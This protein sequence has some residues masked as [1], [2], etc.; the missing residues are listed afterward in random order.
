MGTGGK[1]FL[2]PWSSVKSVVNGFLCD[3]WVMGR[4][5]IRVPREPIRLRSWRASSLGFGGG[6]FREISFLVIF[7]P[8]RFINS[9]IA[10]TEDRINRKG[11]K[12]AK[13]ELD[14]GMGAILRVRR[15]RFGLLLLRLVVRRRGFLWRRCSLR[16]F[17]CWR[18]LR[19][20]GGGIPGRG[21]GCHSGERPSRSR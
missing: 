13:K 7:A 15:C 8:L 6:D 3:L 5:G 11:A 10:T 9:C 18:G 1:Y 2:H 21:G 16:R 17:L 14:T 20:I 12:S 19:R 4:F